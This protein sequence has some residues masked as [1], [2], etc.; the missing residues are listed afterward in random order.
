M[1]RGGW[2]QSAQAWIA[3]VGDQGDW[4]RRWV[5]DPVMSE[6]IRGSR[7]ALDVGCGE[8]RFARIM[9][10][11]EISV[12][13][14]DPIVHFLEFARARDESGHYLRGSAEAIPFQTSSFDLVVTYLT[15][16]DIPDFRRAIQEMTRVLQPDGRLL[17]ANLSPFATT[18]DG[19]VEDDQG[20]RQHFPVDHYLKESS[21]W[22][23]WR[24]I[25]IE[26]YHRPLSAYMEALIGCGLILEQYLEP[27][28]I[29]G[30]GENAEWYRRVPW[31]H[32][33]VWRKP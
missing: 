28:S 1:E 17:I 5:L 22:Y 14:F 29:E 30:A 24:G 3:S 21:Q 13:A 2:E 15:L 8:G 33:M 11:R 23:S 16:I 18:G 27:A 10:E 26:N 32:I 9:A 6:L 12:F 20:K 19:W 7:K 4:L 31:A 25:H